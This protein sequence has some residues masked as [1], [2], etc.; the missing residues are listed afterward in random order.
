LH[1]RRQWWHPGAGQPSSLD[2][3]VEAAASQLAVLAPRIKGIVSPQPCGTVRALSELTAR[4]H[5]AAKRCRTFTRVAKFPAILADIHVDEVLRLGVG[6]SHLHAR[7]TI[8]AGPRVPRALGAP[9]GFVRVTP[10]S[11]LSRCE[12]RR[13]R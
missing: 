3:A 10:G 8:R 12:R 7:L 2:A 5:I 4:A 9:R 6:R 1:F 13:R 11:A